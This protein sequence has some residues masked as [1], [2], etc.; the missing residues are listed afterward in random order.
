MLVCPYF[1]VAWNDWALTGRRTF[2]GPRRVW[3][4]SVR[5]ML[6]S[7]WNGHCYGLSRLSGLSNNLWRHSWFRQ[8]RILHR[9]LLLHVLGLSCVSCCDRQTD[10]VPFCGNCCRQHL[11]LDKVAVRGSDD[12]IRSTR[13]LGLV[14]WTP[15]F[16]DDR[17][18]RYLIGTN[19]RN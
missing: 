2:Q 19:W 16:G 17:F 6:R 5:L 3:D 10:T 9:R 15:K 14:S 7:H 18:C 1:N 12:R 8:G 11:W 13:S 4:V